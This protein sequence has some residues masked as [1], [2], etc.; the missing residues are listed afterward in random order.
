MPKRQ[1]TAISRAI[2]TLRSSFSETQQDFSPRIGVSLVTL[3]H[4]ETSR[5]PNSANA[6]IRL[7]RLA[8]EK[9]L[10]DL[11]RIFREARNRM[12][13]G[14]QPPASE[15]AR[16]LSFDVAPSEARW[17]AALLR[18]LRKPSEY[19]LELEAFQGLFLRPAV[20]AAE[21]AEYAT[22]SADVQGAI[23]RLHA[24]GKSEGE[25]GE[26]LGLSASDV[27]EVLALFRDGFETNEIPRTRASKPRIPRGRSIN[28]DLP[29][30]VKEVAALF[31]LEELTREQIAEKLGLSLERVEALLLRLKTEWVKRTLPDESAV[32][33]SV[34]PKSDGGDS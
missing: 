8:T 33:D 25:I 24:Q 21:V 7:E 17:V 14:D 15:E 5:P 29:A 11:A 30:E 20:D 34:P 6:L 23:S 32:A 4:W 9:G 3:A 13:D 12:I 1:K 28:A 10:T 16:S 31:Y 18:V 22:T 27:A 2:Q 19:E 26:I